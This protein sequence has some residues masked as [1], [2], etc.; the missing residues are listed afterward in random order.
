MIKNFK[1]QILIAAI[2][3]G[4]IALLF[5]LWSHYNL[6]EKPPAE[7]ALKVGTAF[8]SPRKIQPFEL[9]N[10]PDGSTFNNEQL[11]GHWS[12]M[13]FGF[14]N[15]ALL[16]PTTLTALNQFY[17][18][19][20][21]DNVATKPEIYFIS[22]DPE[23]DSLARLQK[24]VTSFNKNFKGATG[25]ETQLDNMTRDLNIL[26]AKVNLNQD[27]NYQIDHSGTVLVFNPEGHLTALFS[28]PIDPK[29]LAEDYKELIKHTA[30]GGK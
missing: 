27:E 2:I 15:C 22:I 29:A 10:A 9:K 13:F 24:Y 4:F 18:N 5:G 11:K 16:C 26:F 23:R 3:F 21:A 19:L 1:S 12:M 28:P 14:T 25:T 8:P 30:N 20:T 17:G 6:S 7:L